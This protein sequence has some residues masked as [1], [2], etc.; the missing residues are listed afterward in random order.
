MNTSDPAELESILAPERLLR[1]RL[2]PTLDDLAAIRTKLE[3]DSPALTGR[4]RHLIRSVVSGTL[5]ITDSQL[6]R[7]EGVLTALRGWREPGSSEHREAMAV[8]GGL[9]RDLRLVRAHALA[10]RRHIHAVGIA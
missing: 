5:E 3:D 10:L 4:A 2:A 8:Y 6:P 1:E 7:L 9:H